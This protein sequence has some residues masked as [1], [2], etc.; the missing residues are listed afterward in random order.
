MHN[1]THTYKSIND[2]RPTKEGN[3]SPVRAFEDKFLQ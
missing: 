3:I 1:E 2:V